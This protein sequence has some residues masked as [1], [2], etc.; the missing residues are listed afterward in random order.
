MKIKITYETENQLQQA[1]TSPL[2]SLI[3]AG[4]K[5]RK[6]DRYAPFY[7]LYIEVRNPDKAR[8]GRENAG[9]T[10]GL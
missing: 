2:Q 6:S 3:N 5:V 1:L 8:S 9:H 10:P 4:A 7:H